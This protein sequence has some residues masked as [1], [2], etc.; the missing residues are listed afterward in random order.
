MA[1]GIA[2]P[3]VRAQAASE[4]EVKA[5]FLYKFASFVEWPTAANEPLVICVLGADPFGDTLD[6][7]VQGKTLAGR[8]F[9]VRRIKSWQP[10]ENCQI[11]YISGSEKPRLQA[12]L[13]RLRAL[14]ILTVGD[15]PAFC[16]NGGH[17]NL[18]LNS[19]KVKLDINP[20]AAAKS[21]LQISSKLLN[22]ARIVHSTG[23]LG[24][25]R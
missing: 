1:L 7:A 16:E 9:A 12:T 11:L 14:A 5:A 20:D 6:R 19:S 17:I 8:E 15:M 4:Y 23:T 3:P 18:I 2:D 10:G 24:A 22:L 25:R 21:G 13:D